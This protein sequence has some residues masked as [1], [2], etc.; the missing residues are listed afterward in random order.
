MSDIQATLMD[1]LACDEEARKH[2]VW[3]SANHRA[4]FETWIAQAPS[5]SDLLKRV[6][7]AVDMLA[8]RDIT[9][10]N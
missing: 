6:G 9:R 1:A 2:Y 3:L 10:M 8:G 4:E 7:A 5:Q